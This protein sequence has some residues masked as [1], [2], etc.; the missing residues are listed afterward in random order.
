MK[1]QQMYNDNCKTKSI[2]L[3]GMNMNEEMELTKNQQENDT[4]NIE[5]IQKPLEMI[6]A[7]AAK[8]KGI[9]VFLIIV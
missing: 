2:I 3:E 1:R 9:P 5:Q 6:N 7:E 8:E 4:T